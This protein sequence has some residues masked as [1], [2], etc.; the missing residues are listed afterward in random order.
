[1]WP[2]A[3]SCCSPSGHCN[4]TK[5]P[6]PQNSNRECKQIALNHHK[7]VDFHIELPIIAGVKID[8]PTRTVEAPESWRNAN[9]IEPSP[10]DRQVLN[11][12][13]LI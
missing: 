2:G 6:T 11:S 4:K 13:F 9:L 8:L 12:T 3:K 5:T 7:S 10:P 1:M